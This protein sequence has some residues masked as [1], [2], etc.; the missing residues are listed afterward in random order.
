MFT[1]QLMIH[2]A[3]SAFIWSLCYLIGWDVGQ[4]RRAPQPAVRK[5][6]GTAITETLIVLPVLML[7]LLGTAQLAVNNIGMMLI[8]YGTSQAARTVWVW[9]PE[10]EPLGEEESRMGVDQ[11]RVKEM[12]RLQVAAAMTPVAPAAFAANRDI[13]SDQ[14]VRMR[15]IFLASQLQ[16]PPEDS[17]ASVIGSARDLDSFETADNLTLRNALDGASFPRRT[18]QKFTSAYD[19]TDIE[20]VEDGQD[21]TVE[22]TYMHQLTFPLMGPVFGES[23][24]VGHASGYYLE[25]ARN[26][27]Y[28]AQR[29]PNAQ[30]PR[31]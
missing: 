30:P 8:N 9:Q 13:D 26:A 7:L 24:T 31:M 4:R 14:F 6:R 16:T 22:V 20:V 3:L 25:L 27:T 15:A 12:A 2:G 19:A 21:V 10:V 29:P 17:G 11:R 1:S 28:R 23:S 5:A 18:V